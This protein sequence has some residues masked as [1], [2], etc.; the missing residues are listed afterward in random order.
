M[1]ND[2]TVGLSFFWSVL[3]ALLPKDG[4]VLFCD[5]LYNLQLY[6]ELTLAFMWPPINEY[7]FSTKKGHHGHQ[8]SMG[9]NY[10]NEMSTLSCNEVHP[11][12][13][14]ANTLFMGVSLT[15]AAGGYRF[16]A[17]EYNDYFCQQ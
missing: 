15:S 9:S 3:V 13:L 1:V 7:R 5:H 11:Y 17:S 2:C 10:F 4:P 14:S 8:T 12:S 6:G 16:M